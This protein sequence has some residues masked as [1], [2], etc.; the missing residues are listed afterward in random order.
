[1]S[2]RPPPDVYQLVTDQVIAALKRGVVPWQNPVLSAGLPFNLISAKHYR[3]INPFVL[4]MTAQ[5]KGYRRP[6]WITFK[7]A[8]EKGASVRQ[9]EKSTIVTFFKPALDGKQKSD[10][11]ARRFVLRYYRVFNVEQCDGLDLPPF[12]EQELRDTEPIVEAEAIVTGFVEERGGPTL[13]QAGLRAFYRPSDD[14]VTVPDPK[15][16]RS[17]EAWY[18]TIFHEL[19]H[20]TGHKKRL[21]REGIARMDRFGSLKYAREELIAEM[22]AAFLNADAGIDAGEVENSAAY[23]AGWLKRLRN[24][25]K[26]VVQAAGKAQRAADHIIGRTFESADSEAQAERTEV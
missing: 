4:A 5:M 21:D 3:G 8:Q 17:M 2:K 7:Q 12:D 18:S 22:G 23:I 15:D 20:S 26:L 24:D 19:V 13:H 1:M 11:E 9:G 10:E 16:C 14:S 6:E 25:A